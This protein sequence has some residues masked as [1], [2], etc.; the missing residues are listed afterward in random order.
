MIM[1]ELY[2]CKFLARTFAGSAGRAD[3]SRYGRASVELQILAFR[4]LALSELSV[5]RVPGLRPAGCDA[6]IL[7]NDH[8]HTNDLSRLRG[9]PPRN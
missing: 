7:R 6:V 2:W 1:E 4:C 5:A 3:K 9:Q 8:A